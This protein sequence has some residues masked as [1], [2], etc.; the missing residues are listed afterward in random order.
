MFGEKPI[1]GHVEYKMDSKSRLFIPPFTYG[2][3]GDELYARTYKS[4]TGAHVL[5]IMSVEEYKNEIQ[6]LRNVISNAT[7]AEELEKAKYK[8]KM[9]YFKLTASFTISNQKR[10]TI[11]SYLMDNLNWE[12]E[13]YYKLDGAG[14]S[15][16]ISPKK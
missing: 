2:E 4:K 8:L 10:I 1:I 11:P 16:I 3:E 5:E 7:T 13:E 15:L 12:N 6:D 14:S 9:L